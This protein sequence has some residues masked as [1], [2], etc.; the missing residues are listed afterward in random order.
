M[1]QFCKRLIS[2][3]ARYGI[4]AGA[5]YIIQLVKGVSSLIDDDGVMR[6]TDNAKLVP[7]EYIAGVLDSLFQVISSVVSVLATAFSAILGVAMSIVGNFFS[8]IFKKIDY[9]YSQVYATVNTD[10]DC[11]CAMMPQAPCQFKIFDSSFIEKA[12]LRGYVDDGNT[13]LFF[14]VPGGTMILGPA[15]YDVEDP[16][17][18]TGWTCE[19][20][21][22]CVDSIDAWKQLINTI[23]AQDLCR[24]SVE[25]LSTAGYPA[26]VRCSIGEKDNALL[27]KQIVRCYNDFSVNSTLENTSEAGSLS[28]I[29]DFKLRR[30]AWANTSF[31]ALWLAAVAYPSSI[32]T[33]FKVSISGSGSKWTGY[34]S[35]DYVQT[36]GTYP[37]LAN[38]Q[39]FT[40]DI[41]L[42]QVL[43][44]DGN[45]IYMSSVQHPGDEFSWSD[46]L[47]ALCVDN[48]PISSL[49]AGV[50]P[51]VI[52]TKRVYSGSPVIA[53]L[54]FSWAVALQT[55]W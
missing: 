30:I 6:L 42:H 43:E 27:L 39:W 2:V 35:N 24:W 50:S 45:P 40:T 18:V 54:D 34:L 31:F 32:D 46:Y 38:W 53:D 33:I 5:S 36:S 17:S 13:I 25:S 55:P 28:A 21:P 23:V 51:D 1:S 10:S 49:P 7:S 37:V 16:T 11:P 48:T 8:T 15:E 19:F 12:G 41:Y 52:I 29:D 22:S 44:L 3:V 14:S 20:H 4:L 47:Q 9:D 26:T